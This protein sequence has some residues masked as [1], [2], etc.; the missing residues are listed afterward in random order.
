MKICH[1]AIYCPWNQML[2]SKKKIYN[3][4]H[5]TQLP[6]RQEVWYSA[7][8][9]NQEFRSWFGRIKNVNETKLGCGIMIWALAMKGKLT[10]FIWDWGWGKQTCSQSRWL[11]DLSP[12][13]GHWIHY[14]IL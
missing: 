5:W 9:Q 7:S 12:M 3:Y 13:G 1:W 2:T 10:Q 4:C 8:K 6:H 11:L 14:S